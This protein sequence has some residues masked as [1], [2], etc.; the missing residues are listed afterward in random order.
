MN[1]IIDIVL[2]ALIVLIVA[3]SSKRGFILTVFDFASGIVAFIGARILSPYVSTFV[4]D[5]FFKSTVISFLSE[6]YSS[7]GDTVASAI[8]NM[9]SVFSFLPEGIYAYIKESG[10]IDSQ[11][12]SQTIM[13]NITTVEQLE[14]SIVGPIMSSVIQLIAFAVL[15]IVLLVVLRIAAKFISRVVNI[16][17][18]A[19][20]LN[21]ILGAAVG[22]L[23]GLVYVFIIA[24]VICVLSYASEDVAVYAADSYICSFASK[25]IGI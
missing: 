1:Y 15:S 21:S 11:A 23:K 25:L 7:A 2:I 12:I 5:N 4:Y 13:T 24:V 22:L 16:S 19:G 17:K 18:I 20:K 14:S 6:K 3:V 10:I 8:D 9:Y